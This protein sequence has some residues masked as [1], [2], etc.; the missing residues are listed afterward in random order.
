MDPWLSHLRFCFLQTLFLVQEQVIIFFFSYRL[1][2]FIS[3]MRD[4]LFFL[5]VNQTRDPPVRPSAYS[6]VDNSRVGLGNTAPFEGRWSGFICCLSEFLK[7]FLPGDFSLRCQGAWWTSE[8]FHWTCQTMPGCRFTWCSAWLPCLSSHSK[9]WC[10]G[11]C[12]DLGGLNSG[13]LI[14]ETVA[15][16]PE[17]PYIL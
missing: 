2:F 10:I 14:Q 17:P 13:R 15:K 9:Q 16:D 3:V 12:G 5:F 7:Y 1:I 8:F 6:H 11:N 4:P